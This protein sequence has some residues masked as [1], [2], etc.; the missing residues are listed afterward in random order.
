[1]PNESGILDHI[2]VI[3]RWRRMIITAFFVVTIATAVISFLLPEA[4]RAN[5]VVYPPNQGSDMLGL[6]GLMGDLPLGLLGLGEGGVSATD[7]VPVLESERVA[8]AVAEKFN[9]KSE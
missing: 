2:A 6:S 9:L 7:F 8:E 5:A 4:Y 1:M 3:V